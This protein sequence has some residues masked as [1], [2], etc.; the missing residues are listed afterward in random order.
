M[1]IVP[2]DISQAKNQRFLTTL[3]IIFNRIF[4]VL[5]ILTTLPFFL[6]ILATPTIILFGIYGIFLFFSKKYHLFTNIIFL[7]FAAGVYL[8]PLPIGWGVYHS[9]KE[10]RLGGFNFYSVPAVF[11]IP[12][13]IFVT[14][15]V[16]NILGNIQAYFKSTTESRN[17]YF[18]ISFGI[19]L[20]TLVAFPL[21]DSVKVRERAFEDDTGGGKLPY[22]LTK[23]ELNC[24]SISGCS[25]TAYSRDYTARFDPS[26]K[27]YVYDLNLKDSLVESIVFTAVEIDGKKI[28]FSTDSRVTCLNCQKN[29][30]EPYNLVFPAGKNVDFIISNDKLIK[31]I[32][33]TEQ[34]GIVDDFFF[35]K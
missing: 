22:V 3:E 15:A 11:N 8:I 17:T 7:I 10:V 33:F 1:T 27:K 30:S 29:M 28:N 31:N 34:G 14:F 25:S 12:T 35:W 23:Q 9:L 24:G 19:V 4:A 26:T 21:F 5:L 2:G 6:N 18:L 32:K 16:R 13:L 20:V